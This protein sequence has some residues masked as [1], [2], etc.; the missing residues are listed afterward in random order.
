MRRGEFLGGG[1]DILGDRVEDTGVFAEDAD[2]EDFLR[3]G[4]AEVL[5]LRVETCVL[6]AEVG[7]PKG[8]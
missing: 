2:I 3:V 5:K 1:Q 4:E 6:G 8:G 7:Y